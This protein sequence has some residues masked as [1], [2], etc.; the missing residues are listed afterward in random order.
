MFTIGLLY[1]KPIKQTYCE[2]DY[3]CVCV[4]VCNCKWVGYMRQLS[5]QLHHLKR[6]S[7]SIHAFGFYV[8]HSLVVGRK[9]PFQVVYITYI[10]D[11]GIRGVCQT[12]WLQ[13]VTCSAH[14]WPS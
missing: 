12:R 3:V 14:I 9:L 4:Y 10:W 8:E 5:D 7:V 13:N 6:L 1:S 2:H 11:M